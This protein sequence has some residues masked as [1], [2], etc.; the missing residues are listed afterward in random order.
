MSDTRLTDEITSPLPATRWWV[1]KIDGLAQHD[2][3]FIAT[4]S[5]WIALVEGEEIFRKKY[6]AHPS[7]ALHIN[8]FAIKPGGE[9]ADNPMEMILIER[10]HTQSQVNDKRAAEAAMQ[11]SSLRD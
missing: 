2:E 6:S 9:V 8:V 1:V 7:A 10:N 11:K 5:P 3:F 4:D